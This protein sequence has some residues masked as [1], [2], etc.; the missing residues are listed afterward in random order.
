MAVWTAAVEAWAVRVTEAAKA[1]VERV[2]AGTGWVQTEVV[3][4]GLA[5]VAGLRGATAA[6]LEAMEAA[7][8]EPEVAV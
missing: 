6:F 7:T 1:A 2:A 5:T 8:Q 4:R 3:E